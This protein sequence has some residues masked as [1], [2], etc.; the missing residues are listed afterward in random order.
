MAAMSAAVTVFKSGQSVDAAIA[1]IAVAH[2]V[3]RKELR[4][5]RDRINRGR[6]DRS[7]RYIYEKFLRK[8][9]GMTKPQIMAEVALHRGFVP[10]SAF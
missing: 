10:I 2:G 3:N 9:K 4:N 7:S 1:E 5:F 8:F 6:A